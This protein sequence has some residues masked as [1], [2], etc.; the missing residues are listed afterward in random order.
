[1]VSWSKLWPLA[2]GPMLHGG[3]S[4]PLSVETP[5]LERKASPLPG[6]LFLSQKGLLSTRSEQER[7]KC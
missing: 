6:A 5:P 1:M 4:A 3:S 7:P 2:A